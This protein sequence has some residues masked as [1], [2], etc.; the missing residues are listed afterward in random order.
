MGVEGG[1]GGFIKVQCH[2]GMSELS[3]SRNYYAPAAVM[4]LKFCAT[5]NMWCV[6]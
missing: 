1:G 3:L 4:Q 5:C 6:Y 2:A